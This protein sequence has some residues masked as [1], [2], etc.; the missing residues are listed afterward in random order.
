MR[1]PE[2][3]LLSQD[4]PKFLPIETAGGNSFQHYLW[5]VI[6]KELNFYLNKHLDLITIYRK[7]EAQKNKHHQKEAFSQI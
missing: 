2:P 6:I 3:K 4:V 7:Y 1:D 5:S